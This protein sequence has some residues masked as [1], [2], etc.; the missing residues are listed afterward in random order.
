M[1]YKY[2]T[3]ILFLDKLG[4]FKIINRFSFPR[5]GTKRR[6]KK[7][8]KHQVNQ[9]LKKDSLSVS[10]MHLSKEYFFYFI[11]YQIVPVYGNKKGNILKG[12]LS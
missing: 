10:K 5:N 1:F 2:E 7:E 8:K 3:F 11:V 6:I 4:T 12:N 9:V